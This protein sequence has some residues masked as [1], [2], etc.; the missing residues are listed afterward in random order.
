MRIVQRKEAYDLVT[1]VPLASLNAG[2]TAFIPRLLVEHK[3]AS[4]TGEARRL[5]DG[6]GVEIGGDRLSEYTVDRSKLVPGTR[7]KV[8][9]RRTLIFVDG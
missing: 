6:G 7:M 9:K 2:D 4:S 5:I 8:G 1:E 3:A